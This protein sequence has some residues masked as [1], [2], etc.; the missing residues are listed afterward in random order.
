MTQPVW[1]CCIPKPDCVERQQIGDGGGGG[2]GVEKALLAA[3]GSRRAGNAWK[4]GN[5]FPWSTGGG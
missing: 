2:G 4:N 5:E 3:S 1:F